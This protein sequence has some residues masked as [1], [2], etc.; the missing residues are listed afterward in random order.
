M[1][2]ICVRDMCM[3]CVCV[4]CLC[5][6]CAAWASWHVAGAGLQDPKSRAKA[7]THCLRL[8]INDVVRCWEMLARQEHAIYAIAVKMRVVLCV[9]IVVSCRCGRK[10]LWTQV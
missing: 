10:L 3:T 8:E 5:V 6:T 4:T 1:H 2:D 7:K 9:L